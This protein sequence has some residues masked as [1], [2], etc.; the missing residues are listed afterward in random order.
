MSEGVFCKGCVYMA[1]LG[2]H[3]G[4]NYLCR[5]CGKYKPV[6]DIVDINKE[7]FQNMEYSD[8]LRDKWLKYCALVERENN[9]H[10]CFGLLSK[11]TIVKHGM[12]CKTCVDR[13]GALFMSDLKR[14]DFMEVDQ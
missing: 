7:C 3:S 5:L 13:A 9:I 4:C 2:V 14:N 6:D 11:E 1:E 12:F 8:D 10:L